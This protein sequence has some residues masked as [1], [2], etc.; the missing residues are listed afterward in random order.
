[1]GGFTGGTRIKKILLRHEGHEQLRN[2]T[3]GSPHESN[4]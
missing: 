4:L 1:L 2:G 3:W